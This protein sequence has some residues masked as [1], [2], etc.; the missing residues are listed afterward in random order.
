MRNGRK[1]YRRKEKKMSRYNNEG[2]P[3]QRA[4]FS[5]TTENYLIPPQPE[6]HERVTVRLRVRKGDAEI[7]FLVTAGNHLRMHL[8]SSDSC[9]DYYSV[10]VEVVESPFRYY[11]EIIANGHRYR[12]TRRGVRNTIRPADWWHVIPG[13]HPPAW[14]EGAVMYQIF[15]DRFYNGDPSNDVYDGEYTYMGRRTVQVRD[16]DQVPSPI[17][18]DE[19][20]GGDLKGVMKKLDYLRDLG[21]EAIY[22]NPIFLSP[23]S[24]KYDVQDYEHIDPHFGKIVRDKLKKNARKSMEAMEEKKRGS[25]KVRFSN[26]RA[27]SYLERVTNPENLAAGDRLFARLVKEAH[28][29]GIRVILDGVFNHC[30]SFHRWMDSER[31]YEKLPDGQKGAKASKNSPYHDYFHFENDLWPSN[32]SYDS[33]WDFGTLP[34]LNYENSEELCEYILRIGR[35]WVSPPYSADGWRLDVAAD[36]SYSE[37]FNHTFWKRFRKAVKEANPEAVIIAENYCDSW[38]WLQGDEW[39]TIMNYEFFMEPVTWF[40][41]GMEKHSDARN[42]ERYGDPDAFWRTVLGMNQESLPFAPLQISMNELSNHDHSRFL[43]RTSRVVGRAEDLG[44]EAASE[45][46]SM[47]VMRQA[48]LLQMTWTGAPTIYYGDEAGLTG[49]TDPDNRRTYP[50]GHEDQGLLQCHRA[51]ARLRKNSPVLRRGSLVRLADEDGLLAYGRFAGEGD[52]RESY[53]VLLNINHIEIEYEV[54]VTY[55]GVPEEAE[56]ECLFVTGRQHFEVKSLENGKI[57]T[58]QQC[59][60]K[61]LGKKAGTVAGGA[62]TYAGLAAAESTGQNIFNSDNREYSQAMPGSPDAGTE[63]AG[64]ESFAAGRP[65][66]EGSGTV[67]A[68]FEGTGTEG[69]GIEGI[70]IEGTGNAGFGTDTGG[71]SGYGTEMTGTEAFAAGRP[72]LDGSGTGGAGFEG[73]GNAGFGTDTAGYSG[74]GI[75]G[76]GNAGFGTE[77]AA[78]SGF[79]TEM[80]G[81][82][83]ISDGGSGTEGTGGA[84]ADTV[85]GAGT[86]IVGTVFPVRGGILSIIL[87]PESGFLLRWKS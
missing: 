17:G 53:I 50:W 28:K 59:H 45:G 66:L 26:N 10:T 71:Y 15:V 6:L 23:S 48:V 52:S 7:C 69:T 68:G 29:K 42:E 67:G 58:M 34:K 78:Y 43:T 86:E 2:E 32:D 47:E 51:L 11:F 14:A 9:F 41:T 64:A 80:T 44:P 77:T 57:V 63:M 54:D 73:T 20:Y 84:G 87:P 12:F 76:T 16:W 30:G 19:F 22:L 39:D 60:Q 1:P 81:A 61:D 13:F 18:Y 55:A 85:T 4:F 62:P 8:S 79:V 38:K 70:G 74:Y 56:L 31:I 46:I 33:W 36:L 35:K 72:G 65:G 83:G 21:V 5:D 82:E 75:E 40:L 49:F 3:D 27:E 37:E 24:H 25:R